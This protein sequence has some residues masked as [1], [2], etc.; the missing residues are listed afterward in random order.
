M[1][2]TKLSK[3]DH[4]TQKIGTD[5]SKDLKPMDVILLTGNLGAGK[6]TF[7]KGVANGLGIKTRI[8]SPTFVVVRTHEITN[9]QIDR[10]YHIDLYRLENPEEIRSIDIQSI[11]EEEKS[12]VVIEWP[13]KGNI[14]FSK[15]IY[16][17]NFENITDNTR[18]IT[19]S[20]E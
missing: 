18:E 14:I 13:E 11:L 20:Y 10:M 4:E 12:L 19:I 6:T 9:G 17:I 5:L 2:K 1:K 16:K 3:S 8:I 15:K 7:V